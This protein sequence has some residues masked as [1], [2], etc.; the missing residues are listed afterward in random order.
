MT[1]TKMSSGASYA[2]EASLA[3]S[4][5]RVGA[6]ADLVSTS[7]ESCHLQKLSYPTHLLYMDI[8]MNTIVLIPVSIMLLCQG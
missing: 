8:E 7:F 2:Q 5:L 3:S 6:A 4:T 1:V